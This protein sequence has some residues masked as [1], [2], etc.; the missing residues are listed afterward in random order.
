MAEQ[1]PRPPIKLT[2]LDVMSNWLYSEG[3]IQGASRRANIRLKVLGNVPRI[4]VK[5]NV[6]DDK[7]NGRIEFKTDAPTMAVIFSTLM[8]LGDGT[9]SKDHYD[10][11]YNDYIFKDGKRSDNRLTLATCRIGVDRQSER[12]YIAVLG[13]NRPK[14]QFFFGPS[15]FHKVKTGGEELSQ[16][17]VSRAYAMG[18]ARTFSN[19]VDHLLVS[20]FDPEA[21]NVPKPPPEADGGQQGNSRPSGGGGNKPAAP[22][23][24]EDAEGFDDWAS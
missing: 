19:Q 6:P 15:E 24:F 10:F 14:V 11:E 12:I 2:A 13:Y 18:F 23:G 16:A 22:G 3:P 7:N 1:T 20:N 17:E 21:R 5:T 9:A 4:V 8:A